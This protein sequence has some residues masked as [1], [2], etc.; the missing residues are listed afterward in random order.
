MV[1][2]G[3]FC[4][5]FYL[6]ELRQMNSLTNAW[7]HPK[8]S[9]AGLLIAIV[10]IAQV[11]SQQGVDLGKAGSGTVVTLIV[12]VA[13]AI[14]GLLARDPVSAPAQE[15]STAKLGAWTLIALV[16]PLPFVAGCSGTK[17]AQDIVNWT[18]ALQSAVATV[19]S[20]AALLAPADA[21]IFTAAT[22]GFDAASNLLVNQ[23]DAY[24]ANPSATTLAQIQNQVVTFQQQVNSALLQAAKIVNPAS[25]QHAL[26]A[27]QA[28][29]TIVSAMLALVQTISSKTAVAQMASHSTIKLAAVEPYLDTTR[30]ARIVADHYGE[31]IEAAA[32]QVAKA[33]QVQAL[34]GF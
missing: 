27:V 8:T 13:T 7:N 14:L 26:T 20:T 25:Q 6:K 18:P 19:D 22:I 34:A 15:N 10:T 12:A 5:P 32:S 1:N 33:M 21:P 29:A 28:V 4:C 3:S 24:L 2:L 11:F 9:V 31:T 30:S 23:A 16:F 17:V